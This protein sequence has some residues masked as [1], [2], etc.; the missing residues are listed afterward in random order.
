MAMQS[1]AMDRK[2]KHSKTEQSYAKQS[3]AIERKCCNSLG[4]GRSDA[5]ALRAR[6]I[7]AE[8]INVEAR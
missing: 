8:H 4:A 3:K 5:K 1:N 6:G 2:A 7:G